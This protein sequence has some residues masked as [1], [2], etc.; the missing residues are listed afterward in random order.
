[1]IIFCLSFIVFSGI[2]TADDLVDCMK[3]KNCEVVP[4]HGYGY[5]ISQTTESKNYDNK[6]LNCPKP[7]CPKCGERKGNKTSWIDFSDLNKSA[8]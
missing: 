8:A 4:E 1:M 6:T 3:N 2:K 5:S 7:K